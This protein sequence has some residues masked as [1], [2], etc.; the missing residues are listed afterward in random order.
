MKAPSDLLE[1]I[2]TD[3]CFQI[4][5]EFPSVNF[6][7]FKIKK[8]NPPIKKFIGNVGVSFCLKRSEM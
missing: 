2:A 4:M 1:T 6:V 8:M 3:F 7:E 5:K